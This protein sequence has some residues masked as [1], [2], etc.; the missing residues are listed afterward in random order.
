MEGQPPSQRAT[1]SPNMESEPPS[2]SPAPSHPSGSVLPLASASNDAL[3]SEL[4]ARGIQ[5]T[6]EELAR[7]GL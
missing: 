3:R 5:L 2:Q 6:T 1:L 4:R 7:L